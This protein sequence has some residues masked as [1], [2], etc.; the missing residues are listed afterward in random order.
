MAKFSEALG[1]WVCPVEFRR[2][3]LDDPKIGGGGGGEAADNDEI[4]PVHD[5][6][7]ERCTAS[8]LLQQGQVSIY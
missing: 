1:R 2:K 8:P 4:D 7:I 3:F 6:V 5:E